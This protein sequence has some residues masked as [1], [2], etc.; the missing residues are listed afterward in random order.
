MTDSYVSNTLADGMYTRAETH[1]G[2]TC[3]NSSASS[4]AGTPIPVDGSSES[5]SGAAVVFVRFKTEPGTSSVAEN[6]AMSRVA[7]SYVRAV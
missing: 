2:L 3:V 5:P 4:N 6:E 1:L 7:H